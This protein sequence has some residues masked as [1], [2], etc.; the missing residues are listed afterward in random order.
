MSISG[1]VVHANPATA[2][3]L[4]TRLEAINGVEVH[5]ITDE[6]KMVVTVDIDDEREAADTLMNLQRE[7][8]VLSASLIYNHFE[9]QAGH[10]P[11]E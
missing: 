1:L 3:E 9:T 2:N 10:G 6:G 5:T 4:S 11:A 8:G 7:D